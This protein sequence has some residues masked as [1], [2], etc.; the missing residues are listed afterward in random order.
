MAG[1]G[2]C[3]FDARRQWLDL[4]LERTIPIV[5]HPANM[6]F[7]RCIPC[8]RSAGLVNQVLQS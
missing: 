5:S 6:L 4:L 8:L 2:T 7:G 3:L 1:R